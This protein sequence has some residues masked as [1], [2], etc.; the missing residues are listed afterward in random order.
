MR[1][2]SLHNRN[3]SNFGNPGEWDYAGYMRNKGFAARD[4]I[5]DSEWRVTGRRSNTLPV[6][7]KCRIYILNYYRSLGLEGDTY[8]FIAAI[9]LGY[10]AYLSDDIRRLSKPPAQ[11]TCWQ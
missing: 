5:T 4:Y 6:G 2:F 7:T 1:S 3:R 10:K 9:T 11:L 8:A